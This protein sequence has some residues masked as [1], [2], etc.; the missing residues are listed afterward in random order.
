ML[1]NQRVTLSYHFVPRTMTCHVHIIPLRTEKDDVSCPYHTRNSYVT[2]FVPVCVILRWYNWYHSC[3]TFSSK[4]AAK[5][6]FRLQFYSSNTFLI[7][8]HTNH[9]PICGVTK[10][11]LKHSPGVYQGMNMCVHS[12]Y[13]F[14]SLCAYSNRPPP[15]YSCPPPAIGAN[16]ILIPPKLSYTFR[17]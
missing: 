17:P 5:A 10:I 7:V 1:E 14:R 9:T 6:S 15:A 2:Y 12:W 11:M 13:K 16:P 3:N 8:S 4:D